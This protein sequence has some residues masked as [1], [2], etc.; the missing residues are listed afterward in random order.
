MTDSHESFE[1]HV[2]VTDGTPVATHL[3]ADATGL[4]IGEI[5]RTMQAG[6]VWLTRDGYTQRLRRH[7][8]RL[9]V[10]DTLHCYYDTGVLA[11]RVSAPLLIENRAAYSVWD[12]PFGVWSHGTRWGDHCAMTRLVE[13]ALQ[14]PT[15]IV[16]RLDRATRGV[17]LIAHDKAAAAALSDL[18][19]TRQVEK[20]YHATVSGLPPAV[21]FPLEITEAID[22]KPARSTVNLLRPDAER[23][24]T[25]LKVTLHTG[26][27][28]QARRHLAEVGWPIVGDRLYGDADATDEDLQLVSASLA[29]TCPLNGESLH[30]ESR[31]SVA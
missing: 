25:V 6:A 30:Y 9:Q 16:H 19:K 20:T 7:K 18:F 27:K 11:Q 12:K 28:H 5:K 14:R 21:N 22:D 2:S 17:M 31:F 4:S 23:Q 15:F 24:R 8:R 1:R 26:R 29:F 13:Q 10:G 3:L